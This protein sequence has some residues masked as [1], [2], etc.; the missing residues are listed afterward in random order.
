MS[1]F[2]KYRTELI[3]AVL[4]IITLFTTTLVGAEW[5][6]SGS[7]FFTEDYGWKEF[8]EG[9]YFS[10]P[11]LGILTV[12][13]FGHYITAR[14]YKIKVTLPFYIPI[15]F[16]GTLIGTLGA[17]IRIKEGIRSRKE[18]FDIGI[19]GPLAGFVVALAVLFYGFTHLPEPEDIYTIH[20]DYEQF[21]LDYDQ[22]V[23]SYEYQRAHD[24]INF[25][26]FYPEKDFKAMPA[27]PIISMG[28]NL[29]ILFFEKFVVKDPA[30]IPNIYEIMHYPWIY[31]G[32][33]ALVF[34]AINL[35]PIGQLDGGH[36]LYGLFGFSNH[37]RLSE[38]LFF[39]LIFYSGIGIIT[40]GIQSP[41]IL[42]IPPILTGVVL[43]LGFLYFIF[44]RLERKPLD[45]L[46]IASIILIGQFAISFIYPDFQGFM[47]WMVFIFIIGRVIGVYHPKAKYDHQLSPTRKVLGWISLAVFVVSFSP[48]P[49]AF[50]MNESPEEPDTGL[51]SSMPVEKTTPAIDQA[52]FF[53]LPIPDDK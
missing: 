11:F 2:K 31:A 15:W 52:I 12:H 34:T 30:R 8:S 33:L 21:G 50:E 32:F 35:I 26:E 39:A 36:V 48:F 47:G 53:P 51:F 6:G 42:G 10:I 38:M 29:T 14:L 19:A 45:R 23:Y 7:L 1:F 49:F 40:P 3:Q 25:K 16:P 41:D 4:F 37:K 20:P 46:L 43:Y 5:I 17:V 22:H 27:Y 44:G 13:E 18:Y 24:S 9:F 28:T